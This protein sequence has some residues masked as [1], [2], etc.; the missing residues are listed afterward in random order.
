MARE[1]CKEVKLIDLQ[2]RILHNI[3]TT[4]VLRYKMKKRHD[5]KCEF[6]GEVDTLIHFFVSCKLAKIV[7]E[8]AAKLISVI[9][10]KNISLS[11]KK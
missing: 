7:W 1:C 10:G 9:I 11:A 2:W 4:G 6:C 3:F 5:D 8:E